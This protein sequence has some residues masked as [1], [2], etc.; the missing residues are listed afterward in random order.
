[1][2]TV[3]YQLHSAF[4]RV[5]NYVSPDGQLHM[6]ALPEIG[7]GPGITLVSRLP[8][9]A[10]PTI[11]LVDDRLN[12]FADVQ[13][14]T[15]YTPRLRSPTAPSS[16]TLTRA[17]ELV[18]AVANGLTNDNSVRGQL[19]AQ[20]FSA[21]L[22]AMQQGDYSAGAARLKGLGPGLTPAGDD[23]LCGVLWALSLKG[24]TWER[25]R[26]LI[27]RRALGGNVLSNHFL[28]AARA[29]LFFAHFQDFA[30]AICAN[31]WPNISR[32]FLRLQQHGATSGPATASG[33]LAGCR[34]CS[35]TT[36]TDA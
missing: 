5:L 25:P 28:H 33:F 6:L 18:A 1:V 22:M 21:A 9:P 13:I 2:S 32:H 7:A 30:R 34:L 23:F 24:H 27:Y 11:T 31:D 12:R 26:E 17:E 10:P 29:G 14:D 16:D 20:S 15:E 3:H 4:S 8:D 19:V 36:S 35:D